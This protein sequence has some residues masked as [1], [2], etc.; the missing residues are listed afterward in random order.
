MNK[1]QFTRPEGTG[2][3]SVLGSDNVTPLN[4]LEKNA[5]VQAGI[6][7][8]SFSEE[9]LISNFKEFINAVNK[10]KPDTIKGKFINKVYLSTS[11]GP[12]IR[13]ENIK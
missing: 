10:S 12:S 8:M 4:E 3:K 1:P 5:I 13:I 9:N 11:M 7:K 2:G 6:G